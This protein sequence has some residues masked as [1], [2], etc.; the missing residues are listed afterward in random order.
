[1]LKTKP[2]KEKVMKK[3]MIAIA[4]VASLSVLTIGCDQNKKSE[5]ETT[6][7]QNN[8]DVKT[9]FIAN[10]QEAF[11]GESNASAKYEFYSKKAEEQGYK[12]VAAMFKATSMSEAIHA[13]RHERVLKTLDAEPKKE[14]KLPNYVDVAASL[15]DGINGETEEFTTMYPNFIKHA[16]ENKADQA[17]VNAF[18]FAM[19]AEKEHAKMYKDALDNLNDWKDAGKVFAV[20]E[21]CGYTEVGEPK[22]DCPLCH[23]PA[24]KFIVF[25]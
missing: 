11:N 14:I 22:K 13:K 5:A 17:I 7:T 16:K 9:Q 1:M 4:M 2:T 12:S 6:T 3:S 20:C 21:V 10:L 8:A 25:K 23:V 19:E 15:Q 24:D 18:V